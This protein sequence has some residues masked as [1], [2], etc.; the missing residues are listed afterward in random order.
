MTQARHIAIRADASPTLG[1]GHIM[2]CLV[3]ANELRRCGIE[4]H[5]LC[6]EI[7]DWAAAQVTQH[8]HQLIM[9][10]HRE[11]DEAA[12]ISAC[13]AVGAMIVIVDH[14]ALKTQWCDALVGAGFRLVAVDDLAET[15]RPADLLIDPGL[16]R[17]PADYDG[18]LP[19][20]SKC[21]TGAQY[22]L[23]RPEFALLRDAP[24]PNDQPDKHVVIS[25]GGSDPDGQS[26]P[27]LDALDGIDGVRVTLVLTSGAP[28]LS[29]VQ[30]RVGDMETPTSLLID[31]HDMP[32]LIASA[33]LVLGAGGSSA[34][35]RCVLAVPTLL[36]V[37]A[38]NQQFNADQLEAA[39]AA[40]IAH[41]VAPHALRGQVSALLANPEALSRMSKAAHGLCDGRG[42]ARSALAVIGLFADPSLGLRGATDADAKS[43]FDWQSEP[44]ARAFAR[45]PKAPSWEEHSSWFAKRLGRAATD[46]FLIIELKGEAQGFVRLDPSQ[47]AS[48]EVSILLSKSARGKGVGLAALGH[49][50]LAFPDRYILASVHPDNAASQSLFQAAGFER[51]EKDAFVSPGWADARQPTMKDDADGN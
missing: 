27:C 23:L 3:L 29:R 46:P 17:Q 19:Q 36:F 47:G 24:R 14:Y 25:L 21:L 20:S 33:D 11:T 40:V 5:F 32:G 48:W 13:K 18:L 38:P 39:G 10:K 51:I 7:T 22:G 41:D 35:E 49:L 16:G 12:T 1:V 37:L 28:H 30:N 9:L 26:L 6:R 2:R 31:H 8:N 44:G 42:G 15:A 45:N 4:T 50:R 34:L 43:V